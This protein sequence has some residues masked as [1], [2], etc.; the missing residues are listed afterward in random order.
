MANTVTKTSLV[1][2]ENVGEMHVYLASDGASGE[3]TDEVVLDASALNGATAI[4]EIISVKSSLIGFTARLEFDQTADHPAV[5]MPEGKEEQSFE[6]APIVNPAGTGTT[7]DVT[8]TTSGFTASGDV[9]TIVIK[10]RK[11]G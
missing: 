1:D 8:V 5:V 2:G 4:T 9:G 10:Y 11:A 3:L 6:T 7:G